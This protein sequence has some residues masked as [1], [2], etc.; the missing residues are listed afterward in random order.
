[1]R[2]EGFKQ[3]SNR[4]CLAIAY[5]SA[6]D[7]SVAVEDENRGPGLDAVPVPDRVVGIDHRRAHEAKAVQKAA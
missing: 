3:L 1:M 5:E 6:A 4:V 2:K 7:D